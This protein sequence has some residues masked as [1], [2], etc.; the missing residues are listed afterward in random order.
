MPLPD[1]AFWSDRV[2]EVLGR[3]DEPLLRQIAGRLYKPRNQ[4]PADELI[5]RCVATAGNAAV[6]DRRLAALEPGCRKLLALMGRSRQPQWKTGG[7]LELLAALGHAEGLRPVQILLEEGLLYP[8]LP[9]ECPR[10]RSFEQWLGEAAA[11]RYAVFAHPGVI[12]RA[13]GEDL[14][15]PA[16]PGE[17]RQAEKVQEADGLDWPLRLAVLWQ[18]VAADPVRLT[19]QGQFFKRDLDRLRDDPLLNAPA[20]D[21]GTSVPDAGLLAMA[22]ARLEGIIEEAEGELRAGS[23][24]S[25]WQVGVW[26]TLESLWAALPHLKAWNLHDGWRDGQ[27]DVNPFPSAHLLSLLLLARLAPGSWASAAA[28]EQ[29]ILEH[30]PFWKDSRPRRANATS[31]ASGQKRP[32]APVEQGGKSVSTTDPAP[33][34]S[35]LL[36]LGH[37]LRLVQSAKDA[38][39]KGLVRLSDGGRWL[40][41][42]GERPPPP[43]AFS[44]TLLVQPNLEIVAYRQGLT[45]ALIAAVSSFAAWKNLGA[46]CILQLQPDTVYRALES[47]WSFESILHVL[48]EHGMRPPPPAVIESLR[49]WADK[50][51]RL[52][53]YSA[54]A[55][56]E[57][58]T[59]ADLSE[60]LARGL[61]AVRLSD[62]LAV[63]SDENG[64]DYRHFRL[65]GTRDYRLPPDRCVDVESDGVTL[66]IDPVRSDLLLETEL[67]R[68]GEARERPGLGGRRQYVLTPRSL[69][70]GREAGLGPEVLEEWFVQRTGRPLPPAARLLLTGPLAA[71][72]QGRR[73]LVLHVASPDVADGLLQ[74]P[75]T[76]ELIRERL[77][78]AALAVAE[79]DL[80]P[81]RERLRE[82][83]MRVLA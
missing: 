25:S 73:Q 78:P 36:G 70:A 50:R 43:P 21:G 20:A 80:E 60:A 41:G 48:E 74:W 42:L 52:T 61:P 11:T 12:T 62:R 44:K 64:I 10:L 58:A 9:G 8:V 63:V 59:A 40:L 23:L 31:P 33:L 79:E 34:A 37:Q 18:Q 55:L 45:P 3:Y 26:P 82:L 19:Q 66:T 7:L 38:E 47:G 30:H 46:A 49:T 77:G 4:W 1:P 2:R 24:P 13:M 68:F 29:W 35:F 22:M 76:R 54:A 69:A 15:L 39:G 56:F 5:E 72:L 16:C 81:L 32:A 75:A 14:G 6:V 71:P 27:M 67:R 83:G 57:F 51:E 28:V 53:V 65:T 17:V